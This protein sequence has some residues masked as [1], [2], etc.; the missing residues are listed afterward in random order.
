MPRPTT[1]AVM[2]EQAQE[3][4]RVMHRIIVRLHFAQDTGDAATLAR[5]WR[6]LV[7]IERNEQR[8]AEREE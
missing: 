7:A 6:R 8:L 1:E 4:R 5:L 2:Q 3:A